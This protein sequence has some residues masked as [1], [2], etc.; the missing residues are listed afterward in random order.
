[1]VEV[2]KTNILKKQHAKL[3]KKEINTL[4]PKYSINFDLED[5][6][7]ILRIDTF[8]EMLDHNSIT[9]ILYKNGFAIE[10]L[11]DEIPLSLFKT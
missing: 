8:E 5:C 9:T 7:R 11:S 10:I 1:M 6:D 4:F 2:Y 3:I